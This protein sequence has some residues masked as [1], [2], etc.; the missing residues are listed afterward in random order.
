MQRRGIS[1]TVGLLGRMGVGSD[2]IEH[3]AMDIGDQLLE[4]RLF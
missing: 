3:I 4:A 2:L 1:L